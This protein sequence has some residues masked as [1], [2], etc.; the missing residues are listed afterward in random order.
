MECWGGLGRRFVV[1]F[2]DILWWFFKF[3]LFIWGEEILCTHLI[4]NLR[5]WFR[6]KWRVGT[7]NFFDSRGKMLEK[8]FSHWESTI[9]FWEPY[10]I[11][12]S[13]NVQYLSHFVRK[14]N[15]YIY[16]YI[17]DIIFQKLKLIFYKLWYI[18][19]YHNISI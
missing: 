17:Y 1:I 12:P 10:Y 4:L 5:L 11:S 16:I 18:L 3:E 15:I 2:R 7:L 9:T 14:S 6:V 8:Q 19:I 13:K